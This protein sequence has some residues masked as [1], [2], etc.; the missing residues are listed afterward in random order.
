MGL[1]S[2]PQL[3][4]NR[5]VTEW[6]VSDAIAPMPKK[7]IGKGAILALRWTA[8]VARRMG[9]NIGNW[10]EESEKSNSEHQSQDCIPASHASEDNLLG[11]IVLL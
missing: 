8:E 10:N 4:V 11:R 1:E 3:S 5:V 7:Q 2:W 6:E 9:G